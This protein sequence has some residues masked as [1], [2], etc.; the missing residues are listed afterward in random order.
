MK[1]ILTVF[2]IA[3]ISS[4]SAFGYSISQKGI[5]HIKSHESCKLVAY[6]DSN[7]Y[8]I[9]Y[10]HHAK[11]V[12]KGMRISQAQA[13]RY[14]VQDIKEAEEA[15]RRL[16]TELPYKY[17]FS[18]GF[19]DGLV[20]MIYNGGIGGVKNSEFYRRLKNCRVRNGVMNKND[21]NYTCAAVKNF[22]ISHPGHKVRR[23]KTV[24]MMLS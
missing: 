8:S 2:I 13:N 9:G 6:W 5:N 17:K 1:K 4:I 7:G 22:R 23:A 18:Q 21:Y 14:L 15:A 12:H 10:G 19:F 3:L 20:D 24:K 16:I 11:D